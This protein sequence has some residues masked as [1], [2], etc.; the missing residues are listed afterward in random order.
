MKTNELMLGNQL[1]IGKGSDW[2]ENVVI[3]EIFVNSVGLKGR[4]FTTYITTLEP[5][6]ITE[7]MLIKN[8]F[9]KKVLF[10]KNDFFGEVVEYEKSFCNFFVAFRKTDYDIDRTWYVHIDNSNLFTCCSCDVQY[11]HQVQ[12]LANILGFSIEFEL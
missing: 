4:E 10:E 5:I 9:Y 11:I 12:N 8:G 6:Q 7:E 3:D 2:E 1:I